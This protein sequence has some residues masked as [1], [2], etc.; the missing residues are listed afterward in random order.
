MESCM[1]ECHPPIDGPVLYISC[2]E[3]RALLHRSITRCVVGKSEVCV[4]GR[5][6]RISCNEVCLEYLI[7]DSTSVKKAGWLRLSPH[8]FS[9][10]ASGMERWS[11]C[12]TKLQIRPLNT[13]LDTLV[14][15]HV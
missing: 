7:V 5:T 1:D 14:C 2:I 11:P 10:F 4:S 3:I 15:I 12:G 6:Q 8:W 13:G 9:L